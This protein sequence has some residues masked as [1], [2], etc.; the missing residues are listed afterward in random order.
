MPW[1]FRMWCF[2]ELHSFLYFYNF[3][4]YKGYPECNACQVL[5]SLLT[6]WDRF[7]SIYLCRLTFYLQC[8][9]IPTWY[10]HLAVHLAPVLKQLA[11]STLEKL[12]QTFRGLASIVDDPTQSST[13]SKT[14]SFICLCTFLLSIVA[15]PY[16]FLSLLWMSAA[17]HPLWVKNSMTALCFCVLSIVM[18]QLK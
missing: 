16:T 7:N 6:M 9:T 15:S 10:L 8:G 3:R 2:M 4:I 5:I 18:Q 14:F 17:V 1:S 13:L 12:F 11:K